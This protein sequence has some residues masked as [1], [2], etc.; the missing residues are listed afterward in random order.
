ML[1]IKQWTPLA[2]VEFLSFKEKVAASEAQIMVRA[3]TGAPV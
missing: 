1:P 3:T 2:H